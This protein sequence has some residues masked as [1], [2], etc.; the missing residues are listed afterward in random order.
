MTDVSEGIDLDEIERFVKKWTENPLNSDIIHG[1]IWM[2]GS[3]DSREEV[4]AT[5]RA[6]QL[7]ALVERVREA[8]ARIEK[9]REMHRPID[10][11][12]S[13]TICGECSLQLPNGHFFGKV[14]EWPCETVKALTEGD[15]Q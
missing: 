1:L 3:V 12:P 14:V 4:S 7:L 8:E 9:V 15:K 11:E 10:I 2:K 5:L 13:D 6:S